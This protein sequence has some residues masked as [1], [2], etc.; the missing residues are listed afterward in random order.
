[1]KKLFALMLM[2]ASVLFIACS[3]DDGKDPL[4]AQ[5]AQEVL[6][7]LPNEIGTEMG[8]MMQAEGLDVMSLLM[9]T[10]FPFVDDAPVK[11]AKLASSS[12]MFQSI[13]RLST[14]S[15]AKFLNI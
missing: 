8:K 10:P 9:S 5:E 2:A 13:L 11:S 4:S 3:D 12:S 15:L 1:M 7:S 6:S 14:Y